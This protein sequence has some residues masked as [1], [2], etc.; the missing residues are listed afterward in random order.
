M[1]LRSLLRELE[2]GGFRLQVIED[3]LFLPRSLW[4]EL[5]DQVVLWKP[6][7]LRV[8]ADPVLLEALK[9]DHPPMLC[10]LCGGEIRDNVQGLEAGVYIPEIAAVRHLGCHPREIKKDSI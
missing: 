1:T 2:A 8:F 4:A 9:S 7:L 10:V 6:A 5:R 3:R